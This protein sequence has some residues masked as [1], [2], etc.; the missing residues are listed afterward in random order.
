[1]IIII[2]ITTTIIIIIIIKHITIEDLDNW[3]ELKWK[4][5]EISNKKEILNYERKSRG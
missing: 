1:M 5:D 3:N 2:I 4:S